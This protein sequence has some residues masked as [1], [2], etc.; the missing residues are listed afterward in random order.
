[1]SISRTWLGKDT[2]EE[3]INI[4]ALI[5][6]VK[7]TVNLNISR[8]RGFRSFIHRYYVITVYLID[9]GNGLIENGVKR[10]SHTNG[11][12]LSIR[13]IGSANK[14]LLHRINRKCLK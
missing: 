3:N 13:N 8:K 9:N 7:I 6:L 11:F 1:M 10:S 2:N 14:Y 4:C 12:P 5:K